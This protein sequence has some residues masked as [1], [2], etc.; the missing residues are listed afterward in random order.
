MKDKLFYF[1]FRCIGKTFTF[2]YKIGHYFS[3]IHN[4][5]LSSIISNLVCSEK[6]F[7]VVRPISIWG[8]KYI[9]AHSVTS[10][11]N[12][13]IEVIDRYEGQSFS[14]QLSLGENVSFNVNCHIGVINR[15]IIGNNV[16]IGS[17]VLITDHS[18]GGTDLSTLKDIHPQKRELISKGPII[19]EDDVWIGENV[20]VLPNV[21]IGKGSVIGCNTVVNK[22]VPPYSIAV[23][24]PMRILNAK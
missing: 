11:P 24:N 19:I 1:F 2:L 5:I 15:V 8:Y 9:K 16:L 7:N 10:G 3:R 18:H 12:L 14:P 23:G 6:R 22:N 20:C 13:R 21:I 17:N 4:F